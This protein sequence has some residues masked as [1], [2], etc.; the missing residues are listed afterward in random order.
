MREHRGTFTFI[1]IIAFLNGIGVFLI[2]ITLSEFTK[3]SNAPDHYPFL[4]GLVI[5][6][7]AIGLGLQWIIRKYG[8]AAAMKTET[9]S[10][11]RLYREYERVPIDK[12]TKHHSGQVLTLMNRLSD[13]V[14]PILM[15]AFWSTVSSLPQIILFFYFTAAASLTLAILNVI[16]FI[17]FFVFGTWMSRGQIPKAKTYNLARAAYMERFVDFLTNMHTV[18][19]LGLAS[20]TETVMSDR[21]VSVS[22]NIDQLQAFHAKRWFFLHLL[23]GLIFISTLS[24]IALRVGRGQLPVSLLI[25]FISAYLFIRG[26]IDRATENIRRLM[27]YQAYLHNLTDILNQAVERHGIPLTDWHRVELQ[28]VVF[29]YDLNHVPITIP[30]LLLQRGEHL[31]II[32]TSGEGKSTLLNILAGFLEPQSGALTIDGQSFDNLDVVSWQ[33]RIAFVSQ[34]VEIFN[35]SLRENLLLGKTMGDSTIHQLLADLDLEPWVQTLPEGL[36]TVVGEKGV[37]LSAGQ[38]QRLNVAR[39]ILLDRDLYLLDEPISHLDIV[40]AARTI[41]C[42]RA[43]LHQKTFVIVTHH[44]QIRQLCDH[45]YRVQGHTLT[46]VE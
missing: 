6:I 20:Y 9:E 10:L 24:T 31:A 44:D 35:A 3:P 23:S 12:L 27:I 13:G 8:E 30:R 7:Y 14:V 28:D 45:T 21:I 41:D 2:P 34:E 43:R 17:A 25:I 42:I 40:T 37:K 26:T 15:D 32:G 11:L 39:A 19:K 29:R 46:L 33:E 16:L 38:K 18:R 36:N 22:D 5:A 4:I 1:F